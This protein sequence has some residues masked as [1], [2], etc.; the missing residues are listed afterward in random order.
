MENC[1]G[2]LRDTEC[3]PYL[4]DI[5]IFSATFEEHLEHTRMVL[6][7][8]QEHG[9]KLK[10]QKCGLGIL[11]V[12]AYGS[13][14]LTP[15]EKN[16]HLHSGKLEFLELKWAICDQFRD[17]LYYAP[18]FKVYTYNNTLTYVLSFAKLNAT[19]LRWVGELADFNFTI[20]YRPG[21]VN[22]DADTLSRMPLDDTAHLERYTEIVPQE[23][24]QTVACSAKN[25]DQGQVNW[26]S[27]LTGD[28]TVLPTDA[29]RISICSLIE[30]CNWNH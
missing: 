8:L 5:I 11:R 30:Q 18:S 26:V 10:P 23:I 29:V 16:Y 27:A 14:N 9:V 24:L 22:I 19:G 20:H 21:K 25:Q 15:A 1:L 12:V 4:D 7:R 6:Q 17:Y 13:R 2:D 3:V 28:H